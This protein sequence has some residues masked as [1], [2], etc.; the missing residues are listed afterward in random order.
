MSDKNF[1]DL[2]LLRKNLLYINEKAYENWPLTSNLPSEAPL[3]SSGYGA[4]LRTADGKEI[5]DFSSMTMNC[6]LG[7]NDPWVKLCL[8]AYLTSDMP[9]FLTS[10]LHSP[11][12]C[13]Y[14][15][16]LSQL[17]IGGIDDPKIN[18]RQCN[19]SDVTELALKAAS[20]KALG[21]KYV[22]AFAGGY[23]GQN[24]TNYFISDR[25]KHLKFLAET[26]NVLFLPEPLSTDEN[27]SEI[28]QLLQKN[29]KNI[30]ALILEPI[31]MNNG[32]RIFSK[33]LLSEIRAICDKENICLI[34]DEI[35]T[36]FGWLGHLT[37]AE[38]HDVAPDIL[39]LS[40]G[41]TSGNGPLGVMVSKKEYSD[42]PYGCGEKTNG[43]DLRSLV[44]ANAVLDRLLGINDNN[45]LDIIGDEH[46]KDL[47]E[48]FLNQIPQKTSWLKN[49]LQYL[50]KIFPDKIESVCQSG[51]IAGVKL[52]IPAGKFEKITMFSLE[53]GLLIRKVGTSTI[54]IKP[55]LVITKG[56]FEL[57]AS[58]LSDVI[59]EF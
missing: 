24:L 13:N 39:V 33:K 22:A 28:L 21:R 55:P 15:Y 10:R 45:L 35:Q 53:K 2:T 38:A 5:I 4:T 6:C 40:K 11:I 3:I 51:L 54:A 37:A 48:G 25:Q 34:F 29:S 32:V 42:L 41:I 52:D 56:E 1:I 17:K 14:P 27:R 58:I 23:H 49:L 26:D 20:E 9:S 43:A 31:Q 59:K 8:L 36:A 46:R 47:Q 16:R 19:G 30:Y 44:A 12:Y 50:Q 57:G 18:H 7:Q